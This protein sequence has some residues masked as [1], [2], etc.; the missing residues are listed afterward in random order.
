MRLYYGEASLEIEVADDG[1]GAVSSLG[2]A[3][4]GHGLIGMRERV[5]VCGGELSAHPRT[6]GG[7]Q[8][9]AVLP[10]E[11]AARPAV[12]PAD[13]EPTANHS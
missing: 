12:A 3:G 4:S 2:A 8:V 11:D 6:G 9:R 10:I 5:E 1:R 13:A 7:Y